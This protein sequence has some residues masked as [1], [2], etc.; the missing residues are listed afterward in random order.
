MCFASTILSRY[1]MPG[2]KRA[3]LP[4]QRPPKAPGEF[5]SFMRT[6][7]EIRYGHMR[8]KHNRP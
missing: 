4:R 5:Y 7:A 6:G 8:N 2:V 3:S 1:A